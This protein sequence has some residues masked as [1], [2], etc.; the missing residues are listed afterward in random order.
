MLETIV[1]ENTIRLFCENSLFNFLNCENIFA[2]LQKVFCENGIGIFWE[3]SLL[4]FAN[5]EKK[6]TNL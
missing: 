5:Y 1:C 3:N 6:F 4:N 2:N